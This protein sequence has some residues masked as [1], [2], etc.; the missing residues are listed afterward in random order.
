MVTGGG[1]AKSKISDNTAHN[2]FVVLQV[3]E[4]LIV[5]KIGEHF[6]FYIDMY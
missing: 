1:G 4:R 6:S 3:I 5:N 2:I